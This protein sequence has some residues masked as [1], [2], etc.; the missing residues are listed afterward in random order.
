MKFLVRENQSGKMG[1][2]DSRF[3]VPDL[4]ADSMLLK[5]SSVIWSSQREPLKRRWARRS[6]PGKK[7]NT[8]ESADRRE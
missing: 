6:D 1:P 4:A 3:I 7:T 5:T 8:A 2:F